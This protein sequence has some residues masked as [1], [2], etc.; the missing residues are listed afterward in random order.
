MSKKIPIIMAKS[1]RLFDGELRKLQGR[2]MLL[3]L[4]KRPVSR[5]LLERKMLKTRSFSDVLKEL[6]ISKFLPENS[7]FMEAFSPITLVIS[8]FVTILV[9]AGL[10]Y[11][12]GLLSTTMHGIGV[13]ND[14][15]TSSTTAG[16]VNLTRASDITFGTVNDSIQNLRMVA[17]AIIFAELLSVIIVNFAVRG[18][19]PA[20][21]FVHVLIVVL[22][23][24]FSAPVSNAYQSL[25]QDPN[26]FGGNLQTF[27]GANWVM[28]NLPLVIAVVG[29]LGGMFLFIN[30]L[31]GG[32][33]RNLA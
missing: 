11:A 5:A 12:M 6:E 26:I 2:R 8:I 13:T 10:I 24:I 17:L 18:I 15:T 16:Y 4:D 23:I 22:A 28:I 27:T 19:N 9:C 1:D 25:L 3:G 14:M 7:G 30:I 21:F 31:R 33:E 29:I 32:G 20:F